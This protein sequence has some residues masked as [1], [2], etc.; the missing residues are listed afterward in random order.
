MKLTAI[1]RMNLSDA[2]DSKTA[3]DRVN[4][5]EQL[6]ISDIMNTFKIKDNLLKQ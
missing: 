3:V 6:Q 1:P 4:Y 5:H 2:S